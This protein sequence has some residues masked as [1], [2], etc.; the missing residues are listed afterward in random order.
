MRKYSNSPDNYNNILNAEAVQRQ[1]NN[2]N[3]S[4]NNLDREENEELE[5]KFYYDIPIKDFKKKSQFK[6]SGNFFTLNKNKEAEMTPQNQTQNNLNHFY[7]NNLNTISNS[8]KSNYNTNNQFNFSKNTN[9]NLI[10]NFQSN[11]NN[12]NQTNL[13]PNNDANKDRNKR[14][15]IEEILRDTSSGSFFARI[16]RERP[17][18][19]PF[20]KLVPMSSL[21]KINSSV[22]ENKEFNNANSLNNHNF[23]NMNVNSS[24]LLNGDLVNSKLENLQNS[25]ILIGNNP[26]NNSVQLNFNSNNI[27]VNNLNGSK[28]DDI[29]GLSI[30]M[31]PNPN[32]SKMHDISYRIKDINYMDLIYDH[33]MGHY[34]D[35]KS[36][37]YYELKNIGNANKI[38]I[39]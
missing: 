4:I 30:K 19:P 23:I 37:I 17:F 11:L 5:D 31:N 2:L 21:E 33:V 10:S 39:E 18:T 25:Q 1:S 12:A 3:N 32:E 35:P 28:I 14:E 38:E 29:Q 26:M 27:N 9:M 36:N 15:I 22:I 7:Q 16:D 34:Y 8:N 20:T 13:N 6:E 24:H